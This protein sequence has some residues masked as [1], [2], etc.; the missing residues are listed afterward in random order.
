MLQAINSNKAG[1][2]ISSTEVHWREIFKSSEDSLTSTIFGL[3]FYLPSELCWKIIRESCYEFLI[4]FPSKVTVKEYWP[5]WNSVNTNNTNYI[6]PDLFI[7]TPEFDLIIEAKRYDYGQQY[8]AQWEGEIRAYF[9][10][11]K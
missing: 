3:L 11:Y 8:R 5:S 2:N 7:R 4:P 10:E 9:N 1:R 6:E